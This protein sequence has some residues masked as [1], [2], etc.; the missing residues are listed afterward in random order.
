MIT[1]GINKEIG[2]H[3]NLVLLSQHLKREKR[4]N[5]FEVVLVWYNAISFFKLDDNKNIK[6]RFPLCGSG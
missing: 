4:K 2:R 3:T 1:L 5:I 6:M